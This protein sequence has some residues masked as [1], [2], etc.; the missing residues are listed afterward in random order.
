MPWQEWL[1]SAPAKELD[2]VAVDEAAA[3]QVLRSLHCRG[4]VKEQQ[5]RALLSLETR[6]Y[7]AAAACDLPAKT[8]EL[9]PCVP[10]SAK[11]HTTSSHPHR[12]MIKVQQRTVPASVA[13]DKT[14]TF[15]VCLLYTSPSPR[16][17]LLSRM[18]SSA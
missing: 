1:A 16:D 6:K 18:P 5:V 8:L 14:S 17:G 12:V 13:E 15:F 7:T 10:K 2:A 11:V 9:P 4:R 3:V